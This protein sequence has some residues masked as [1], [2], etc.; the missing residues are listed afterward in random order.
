VPEDRCVYA[1]AVGVEEEGRVDPRVGYVSEV[2]LSNDLADEQAFD[3]YDYR[4]PTLYWRRSVRTTP[5]A[6]HLSLW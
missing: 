5:A 4:P 2:A 1:T 3:V 6:N